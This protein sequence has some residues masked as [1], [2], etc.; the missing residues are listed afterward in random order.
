MVFFP[1]QRHKRNKIAE[2][3]MPFISLTP[4]SIRL[5]CGALTPFLFGSKPLEPAEK[6]KHVLDKTNQGTI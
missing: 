5:S 2:Y 1:R 3:Q 6:R 4:F